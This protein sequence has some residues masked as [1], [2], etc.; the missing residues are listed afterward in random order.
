MSSRN[1]FKT[2]K[3]LIP[4]MANAFS[5]LSRLLY[6]IP[7]LSLRSNPGLKLAN[8]FGVFQFRTDALLG[9]KTY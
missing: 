9:N 6:L 4:Q 2:L 5:V 8:A 1:I 7:G 3:G